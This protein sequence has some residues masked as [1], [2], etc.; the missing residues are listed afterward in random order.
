MDAPTASLRAGLAA[1]GVL[2]KLLLP[3]RAWER[4]S[5]PHLARWLEEEDGVEGFLG[6]WGLTA[7]PRVLGVDDTHGLSRHAAER[8]GVAVVP[9][10]F[11]GSPGHLRVSW[12]LPEAS[13]VEGL[14]R[15]SDAI[16]SF[17]G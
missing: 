15:L 13:L 2:D 16:R 4:E 6:P 10:E 3:L 14:A 12:G 17:R 9:G 1:L 7:F 11:F 8:F 5:R